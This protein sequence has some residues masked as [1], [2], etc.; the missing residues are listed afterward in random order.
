MPEAPFK[1][2]IPDKELEFVKQRLQA[3]R[4]PDQLQNIAPWEDGTDLSY[5]QASLMCCMAALSYAWPHCTATA[6][7]SA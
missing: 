5:L 7:S 2:Q 6:C 3:A 4:Y 1:V